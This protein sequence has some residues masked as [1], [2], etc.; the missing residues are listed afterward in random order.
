[1]YI[2]L[3]IGGTTM[4]EFAENLRKLRKKQKLSQQILANKLNVAQSTIGMWE[5]GKRTPKLDDLHRV[6]DV[7]NVPINQLIIS[8]KEKIEITTNE[9]FIDGEKIKELDAKDITQILK[10][11]EILKINK[12]ISPK[13]NNYFLEKN[14]SS[15]KILI[16]DDEREMGELLYSFLAGQKYKVF[17]TFN[18]QMGLE[19]F[20]EIKPD[21]VFLDLTM[22]DMNG[23]DVL[24][25][26]RKISNI[27]ILI[28]TGHPV[29][30]VDIHLDNLKI[31]GYIEKPFSLGQILETLKQVLGE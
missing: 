25:I 1:M 30:I 21:I 13:N 26:I 2:I 19:Y 23:K 31:E 14:H 3:K 15:K 28:I 27:P 9:I 24:K 29:D 6:A 22:P 4:N 12:K 20:E 5:T 16:I 8:L 11:I 10:Q 7:L 18:G 17:L